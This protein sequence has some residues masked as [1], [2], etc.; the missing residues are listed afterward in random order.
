M[1][2]TYDFGKRPPANGGKED[3]RLYVRWKSNG[4]IDFDCLVKK[5]A[6]ASS[7]TEADIRGMMSAFEDELAYYVSEGYNVQLGKIGFFSPKLKAR[8]V[9]HRKD[10]RSASIEM[11]NVNFR[12]SAWLRKSASNVA[13][14]SEMS[15]MR[16]KES[17]REERFNLLQTY[18][19]SHPFITRP[20]YTTLTGLLP[21][22]A[23]KE[24]HAFV[25]EGILHIEGR[26]S[27]KVFMKQTMNNG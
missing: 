1:G 2:I 8:P 18:L 24:L 19:E 17:T 9:L 3:E 22:K 16:S 27:H 20:D 4:T 11:V 14:R 6:E 21:S 25:D 13:E 26:G 15:F 23:L 7:F 10:I 12:S 5:I